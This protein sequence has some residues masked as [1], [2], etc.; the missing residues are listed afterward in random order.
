MR[1][2]IIC[3]EVMMHR[4]ELPPSVEFQLATLHRNMKPR[5]QQLVHCNEFQSIETLLDLAMEVEL[6]VDAEKSFKLP[7]PPESCVYVDLAYRPRKSA[8]PKIKVAA[9]ETKPPP[10]QPP[11]ASSSLEETMAKFA[12]IILDGIKKIQAPSP[13]HG[14]PLH[15]SQPAAGNEST[16]AKKKPASK[17]YA[18]KSS[19]RRHHSSSSSESSGEERRKSSREKR[20]HQRL[21]RQELSSIATGAEHPELSVATARNARCKTR[22]RRSMRD[23]NFVC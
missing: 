15:V 10:T 11:P 22:S 5:L 14:V 4:M 12:G 23:D 2:Y 9:V 1:D 8:T 17:R 16:G 19:K 7:P 13:A 6:A 20:P 18:R 21:R 3:L